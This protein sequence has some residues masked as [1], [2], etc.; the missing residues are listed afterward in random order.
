LSVLSIIVLSV[1]Q[2]K[3]IQATFHTKF[4]KQEVSHDH[5]GT[6]L[7]DLDSFDY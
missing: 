1:P 5:L 6:E 7:W 3:H 4:A 2:G